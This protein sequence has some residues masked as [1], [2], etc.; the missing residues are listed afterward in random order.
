MSQMLNTQKKFSI[1]V[2]FAGMLCLLP[3]LLS[4][5]DRGIQTLYWR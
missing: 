1:L 2:F 4:N 3:K 5:A